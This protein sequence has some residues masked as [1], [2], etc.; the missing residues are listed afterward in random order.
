MKTVICAIAM[1]FSLASA[2]KLRTKATF[3]MTVPVGSYHFNR[4]K[5]WRE[6]NPGLGGSKCAKRE[7]VCHPRLLP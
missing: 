6:W 3:F 5:D 1:S 7:L 4:D 2:Q